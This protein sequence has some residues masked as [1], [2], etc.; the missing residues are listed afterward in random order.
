MIVRTWSGTVSQAKEELYLDA[1]KREVLPR[2]NAVRGYRGSLF[3]RGEDLTGIEYLV[4]TFWKSFE[5][6]QDLVGG[7][8]TVAY[9]PKAIRAV[10]NPFDRRAQLFEIA[11]RDGEPFSIAVDECTSN[12]SVLPGRSPKSVPPSK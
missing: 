2:F 7:D 1:V 8:P 12:R 10:L 6:L 3:L 9:V 4:V 11:F 5:A